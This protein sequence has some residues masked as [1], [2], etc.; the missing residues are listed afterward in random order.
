MHATLVEASLGVYQRFVGRLSPE[1]QERYYEE[2][3]L[4]A[5]LFGTP[6]RVIPRSLAGFRDYFAARLADETIRVTAPAREVASV[7]L[8]ARLPAPMRVLVPAHRLATAALLPPLAAR[9]VRPALEPTARACTAARGALGQGRL[10]SD[11]ARCLTPRA[12]CHSARGLALIVAI[13][14][15][16]SGRLLAAAGAVRGAF[17]RIWSDA[18]AAEEPNRDTESFPDKGD[19]ST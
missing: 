7:I 1:E 4:V 6:A 8:E 12:P 17:R 14:T 3:A 5:R 11:D 16:T 2:M 15:W 18:L 13:L 10:D 19:A 9:G